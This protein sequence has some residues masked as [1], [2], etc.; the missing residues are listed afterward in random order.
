MVLQR[1]DPRPNDSEPIMSLPSQS[2]IELALHLMLYRLR[3]RRI[4][5]ADAYHQLA[6]R[7]PALERAELDEFRYRTRQ[8]ARHLRDLGIMHDVDQGGLG[9]WSLMPK[10]I[11]SCL[12]PDEL[13]AEMMRDDDPPNSS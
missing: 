2:S 9:W 12:D 7:F 10:G 6:L 13:L 8:A 3:G 11:A 5:T 1:A 4:R